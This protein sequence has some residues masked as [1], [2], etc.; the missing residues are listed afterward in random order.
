MFP[1]KQGQWR[2]KKV[3]WLIYPWRRKSYLLALH[4]TA[5]LS[6]KT[7]LNE[8]GNF[9]LISFYIKLCISNVMWDVSSNS[10]LYKGSSLSQ[11]YAEL[12]VISQQKSCHQLKLR[13]AEVALFWGHQGL[14]LYCFC[15]EIHCKGN[16]AWHPLLITIRNPSEAGLI[17]IHLHNLHQVACTSHLFPISRLSLL[18]GFFFIKKGVGWWNKSGICAVNF[19]TLLR[20]WIICS[21]WMALP[22]KCQKRYTSQWAPT[23]VCRIGNK[24]HFCMWQQLRWLPI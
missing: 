11:V 1:R 17:K 13:K 5:V 6:L 10:R 21:E 20:L 8:S 14:N 15:S 24:E 7:L 19:T 3:L 22:E 4:S 23:A 12:I 2:G 18:L 9:M 16:E